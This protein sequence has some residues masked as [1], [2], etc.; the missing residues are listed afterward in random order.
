[1][2]E[3]KPLIS[4]ST[5]AHLE[6]VE[7]YVYYV[8][9]ARRAVEKQVAREEAMTVAAEAAREEGRDLTADEARAEEAAPIRLGHILKSAGADEWNEWLAF[10]A[11]AYTRPFFG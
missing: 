9:G 7:K 10:E 2:D 5:D 1:M 3:C 4:G 11:G 8:D 6:E